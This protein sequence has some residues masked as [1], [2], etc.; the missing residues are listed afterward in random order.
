MMNTELLP[1]VPFFLP[2]DLPPRYL[3]C[4]DSWQRSLCSSEFVSWLSASCI[5]PWTDL[6]GTPSSSDSPNYYRS[7]LPD[8]H[9]LFLTGVLQKPVELLGGDGDQLFISEAD[10]VIVWDEL[11][12]VAMLIGSRICSHALLSPEPY[13][14]WGFF[15]INW[16][17]AHTAA[18]YCR[19]QTNATA[20]VD[21]GSC[22]WK[23]T[24]CQSSPAQTSLYFLHTTHTSTSICL[25]RS[26]K[27]KCR[28]IW[29]LYNL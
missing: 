1:P 13:L 9:L 27:I 22:I 11:A 7:S 17:Q 19:L 15:V 21:W 18:G 26:E 5:P 23:P 6:I 2:A 3:S 10:V 12:Q 28:S 20:P 14:H 24:G 16:L 4:G 8:P 25:T 29:T